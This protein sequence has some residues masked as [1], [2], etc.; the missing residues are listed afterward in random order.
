V[1]SATD[2]SAFVRVYPGVIDDALIAD[3]LALSGGRKSDEDWRRCL[4]TPVVGDVL[5]RFR[6]VVRECFVDYRTISTSLHFCTLLEDPNV[7]RY[8]QST[9]ERPEWFHEHAD[10]WS[11]TSATRQ[12]SVIAYLNDVEK[13]G[14]TVF[15]SFDHAQPCEKGTIVMFP[16]NYLYHHLARPP[17]S[18]PKSVVVTWIHY[19]NGGVPKLATTPLN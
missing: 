7:L 9:P 5:D 11:V 6:D 8:E 3:L 19:G 13:G 2:L 1:T 12:I 18:G 17:E 14:E 10:A 15:T 4:I 16:S